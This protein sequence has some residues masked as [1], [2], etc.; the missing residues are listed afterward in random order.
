LD[1]WI[2]QTAESIPEAVLDKHTVIMFGVHYAVIPQSDFDDF[3]AYLQDLESTDPMVLRDRLL[4]AYMSMPC[5]EEADERYARM[6]KDEILSDFD[7]FL[8]YLRSRFGPELIFEEIERKAFVL[9]REPE[10]MKAEIIEHLGMMWDR[11]F[12]EE[13][14]RRQPMIDETVQAFSGFDFEGMSDEE[15]MRA[16]TGQ[17]NEK[18]EHFMSERERIVFVPS[19]HIGPYT[20]PLI[21]GDTLWMMFS[22]RLPKGSPLGLTQVSRAE[23]LVWLSALADDT[24]LHILTLL[25][26]RGELCAQDIISLLDTSQSTASRHLR[27]LSASGYIR[28]HRTEAGKCYRINAE[29]IEETTKALEGLVP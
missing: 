29:R 21:A 26:D 17:W 12:A 27:Q 20:G 19:P 3:Q 23:L 13:F 1:E 22:C 9:L 16:V 8:G 4:D 10:K 7:T 5:N 28:E 18:L 25:K 2:V 24:R 14:K 11:Y 6:S 15:A